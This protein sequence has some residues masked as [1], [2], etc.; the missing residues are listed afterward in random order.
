MAN[1]RSTPYDLEFLK[2]VGR[3]IRYFRS[4]VRGETQEQLATRIGTKQPYLSR[5][6]WGSA[7]GVSLLFLKQVADALEVNVLDLID[8]HEEPPVS[9]IDKNLRRLFTRILSSS[10]S[11]KQIVLHTLRALLESVDTS[12]H[13][14]GRKKKK[15]QIERLRSN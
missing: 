5:V 10:D 13:V 4:T 6:E 7:F 15:Q 8:N 14:S 2:Q 11:N 9:D 12:A 3:R 1:N